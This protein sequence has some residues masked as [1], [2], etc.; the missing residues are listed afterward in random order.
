MRDRVV[1][2]DELAFLSEDASSAAKMIVDVAEARRRGI[3]RRRVLMM[4][5]DL[6][7]VTA[8]LDPSVRATLGTADGL[9]FIGSMRSML[10]RVAGLS[11]TCAMVSP[12]ELVGDVAVAGASRGLRHFLYGGTID[13]NRRAVARLRRLTDAGVLV[14]GRHECGDDGDEE[15]IVER[16][17][18]FAPDILWLDM[19]IDAA[20]ALLRRHSEAFGPIGVVEVSDGLVDHMLD[21]TPRAPHWIRVVGWEWAWRSVLAPWCRARTRLHAWTKSARRLEKR[22]PHPK[23]TTPAP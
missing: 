22:Q 4:I 17:R 9:H 2:F 19:S 14:D 15:E 20:E 1:A 16:I 7:L 8:R 6:T 21:M 5:D 10:A 23:G 18:T 13:G 12:T 11:P 3:G